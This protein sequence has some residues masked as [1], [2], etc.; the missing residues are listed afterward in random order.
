MRPAPGYADFRSPIK[1]LYQAHSGTHAGGGVN[2]IPGY[3]AVEQIKKD[4]AL[5]R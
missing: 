2:G 5:K 4:G 3:H 1:G